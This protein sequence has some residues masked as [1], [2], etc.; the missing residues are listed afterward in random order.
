MPIWNNQLQAGKGKEKEAVMLFSTNVY[1]LKDIRGF[2]GEYSDKLHCL[3]PC[4]RMS[5]VILL[6]TGKLPFYMYL[7]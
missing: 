3:L 4:L 7:E 6:N 2:G 1:L 5:A